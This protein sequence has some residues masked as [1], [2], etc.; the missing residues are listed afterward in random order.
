MITSK[1]IADLESEDFRWVKY[2]TALKRQ[3]MMRLV[4]DVEHPIQLS[5][6]D[7][8][9]LVEVVEANKRYI[10]CHNPLRKAE[11]EAVR[12]RLLEKTEKK[13]QSIH[14]NVMDGRLK[15]KDKIARKLYR[16]INKWNMERFFSVQY[17]HGHFE[18]SRNE[19]E[20]ERYAVL[21]G[22]YVI[23]TNVAADDLDTQAV[24]GLRSVRWQRS[25]CSKPSSEW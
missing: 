10:L 5:L 13:L 1:R 15:N 3:E 4:E 16:W 6:F 11:D 14:N 22:C 17:G 23:V 12:L 8:Q 24:R 20:I 25:T 19:E 2:I 9:N 7:H 21:D 18:F